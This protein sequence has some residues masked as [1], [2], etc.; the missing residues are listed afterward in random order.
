MKNNLIRQQIDFS[1][2][3]K[4]IIIYNMNCNRKVWAYN[5]DNIQGF[6]SFKATTNLVKKSFKKSFS[7]ISSA[8]ET[9][10][11]TRFGSVYRL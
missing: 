8:L 7:S 11:S 10:D 6:F 5:T 3:Y 1:K 9:G 4:L 2:N